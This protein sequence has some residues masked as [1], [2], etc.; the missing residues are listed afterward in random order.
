[1]SK[2]TQQ[3]SWKPFGAIVAAGVLIA[4]AFEFREPTQVH[5]QTLKTGPAIGEKIPAFELPDHTGETQTF[6]S[7]RGPKG[8]LLL[9]HRS[10]DW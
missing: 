1:M 6:E 5:A 4:F 7:L 3:F 10:A 8:L 9:F 2:V